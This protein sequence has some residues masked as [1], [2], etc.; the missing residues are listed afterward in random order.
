MYM[1]NPVELFKV[2]SNETRLDML[3]W[4]KHPMEHFDQPAELLSKSL[5]ERGGICVGDITEK[6]GLSQSTVSHYLTMM[7][8][9]GLVKSER[10]GKWTYY[11]RNEERIQ[12]VAAFIE[13]EL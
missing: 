10:H 1:K 3:K 2:L 9:V 6:A 13:K 12:E 7:Q 4:L 11:R 8:K 5:N